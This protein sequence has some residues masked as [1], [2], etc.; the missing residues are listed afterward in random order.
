[1]G[2][3]IVAGQRICSVLDKPNGSRVARATLAST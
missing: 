1:M 3:L 2:R